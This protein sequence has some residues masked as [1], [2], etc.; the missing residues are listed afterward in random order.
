[1]LDNEIVI[2]KLDD[3]AHMNEGRIFKNTGI[4]VVK[5]R[6]SKIEGVATGDKIVWIGIPAGDEI[7]IPENLFERIPDGLEDGRFVF[8]GIGAFVIQAIRESG[9]TFG[10]KVTVVPFP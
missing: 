8:A 10:E 1:M 2:K 9:L 7:F 6:G 4:G 3:L 5:E